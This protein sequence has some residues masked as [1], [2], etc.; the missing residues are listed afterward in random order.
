MRL[1]EIDQSI[2]DLIDK[3]TGEILDYEAFEGLQMQRDA[4][5]EQ[6]ALW[7]KNLV[8]DAEQIKSEEKN[9]AERRLALEKKAKSLKSYVELALAGNSY[10]TPKV[11]I[12][13]RK[14]KSV[15]VYD[16][17]SIDSKYLKVAEP[18]ADKTAIKKAIE[19]GEQIGGA[20]LI[21]KNNLQIK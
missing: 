5:I 13:Y 8:S 20:K 1:Y 2:E 14:S 7:H 4:K 11:S 19:N 17:K 3:D 12:T 18:T 6:M 9:L 10:K 16:I 21:E 15:D